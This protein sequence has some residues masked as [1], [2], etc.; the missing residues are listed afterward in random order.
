MSNL[1]RLSSSK[2]SPTTKSIETLSHAIGRVVDCDRASHGRA[3]RHV[4]AVNRLHEAALAAGHN[5]RYGEKIS[6]PIP[7][8]NG[9]LEHRER[10]GNAIWEFFW[11]IDKITEEADGIGL[12]F[13]GA[14]VKISAIAADLHEGEKSARLHLAILEKYGYIR[15]IRTPYGFVIRVVNS[16]KFGIWR[17]RES[18]ENAQSQRPRE[19]QKYPICP[20]KMPDLSGK[21]ARNKEDAAIDAAMDAAVRPLAVC[22]LWSRIGVSPMKMPP[23]FRE[24]CEGLYPPSNGQSLSAY[25]GICLD[26]WAA[27]GEKRYPPD[28]AKAKARIVASE[29]EKALAGR[30]AKLA[31]LP[32]LPP[33]ACKKS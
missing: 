24:L 19:R 33:I 2:L 16:R 31:Y 23:A 15:R 32:L 27:M 13:G 7:V 29:K 1:N 25:M 30:N 11:C 8:W 21:H 6:F 3:L 28:F 26:A 18:G 22:E 14:P 4:N 10:I 5:R 9:L 20:S 12:V 17:A